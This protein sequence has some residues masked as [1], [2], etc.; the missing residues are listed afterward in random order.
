MHAAAVMLLTIGLWA[1]AVL[2]E[3]LSA[4][5]FLCLCMLFAVAPASVVFSGFTS[6]TLWLVLGG[7]VLAEA[8]RATGL[9]VRL[10]R[11]LF[12]RFTLLSAD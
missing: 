5:I 1:T 7:L 6:G 2:P 11:S 8:V 3:H 12:G 4:L 9:G 10:A